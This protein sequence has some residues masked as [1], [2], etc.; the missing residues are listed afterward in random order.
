MA[1]RRR[2]PEMRCGSQKW[3]P[4]PG[5]KEV[6]FDSDSLAFRGSPAL[7]WQKFNQWILFS[8]HFL[9][10]LGGGYIAEPSEVRSSRSLVSSR[11]G[12]GEDEPK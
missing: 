4:L 11:D 2:G 1:A 6:K 12:G 7:P 8:T 10:G 9:Q 3:V 5:G